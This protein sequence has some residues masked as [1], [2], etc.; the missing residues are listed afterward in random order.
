MRAA[1]VILAMLLTLGRACAQ[2]IHDDLSTPERNA[3]AALGGCTATLIAPN[4]MLS[5]AHCTP[6]SRTLAEGAHNDCTGLEQQDELAK[7]PFAA[8]SGWTD[9]PPRANGRRP[10]I[11]FG[12]AKSDPLLSIPIVAYAVPKCADIG[13]LRLARPV[14]PEIA[15]PLPAITDAPADPVAWL[16]GARLRYEGYGATLLLTSRRGW[17]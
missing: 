4:V 10:D 5:V 17:M 13:L 8:E 14:P 2:E 15:V 9:L 16:V 11:R 6:R 7:H 3:V 12:P 1:A